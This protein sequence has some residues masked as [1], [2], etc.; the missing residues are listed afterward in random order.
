MKMYHEY[1]SEEHR[2]SDLIQWGREVRKVTIDESV[3]FACK[4][5]I[6]ARRIKGEEKEEVY[7]DD[8]AIAISRIAD[9]E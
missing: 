8:L 5:I 1:N 2:L 3:I 6:A 4:G 7:W 9:E